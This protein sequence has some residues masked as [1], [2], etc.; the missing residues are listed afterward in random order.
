M[1]CQPLRRALNVLIGLEE[2][3]LKIKDMNF[4]KIYSEVRET[5]VGDV[6]KKY[7]LECGNQWEKVA[8]ELFK[9]HLSFTP[10]LQGLQK[11]LPQFNNDIAE[12]ALLVPGYITRPE[13]M[14]LQ[15]LYKTNEIEALKES[16]TDIVMDPFVRAWHQNDKFCFLDVFEDF[17]EYIH[18][19]L[20]C[21]YQENY[22]A[23]YVSL[24]PI[25]EGVLSRWYAFY[26]GNTQWNFE[27]AKK[28][29]SKSVNRQPLPFDPVFTE[30]YVNGLSVLISEH[31]FLDTNSKAK[32]F[33]FFN[34]H[35]ALHMLDGEGFATKYNVS[36][37]FLI[38]DLMSIVYTNE[39]K[40][41]DEKYLF[42]LYNTEYENRDLSKWLHIYND[43]KQFRYK[44][45]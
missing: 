24:L 38:L 9:I 11:K 27:K 36:R 25:I 45:I 29:I 1:R 42:R 5:S 8:K 16:L 20:I 4:E 15:Y 7:S 14:K 3:S 18:S 13:L 43:A 2:L 40:I 19:S 28:F 39:R 35:Q 30:I 26:H 6:R 34:R 33:D 41:I 23:A 10:P 21:Y 44:Y 22:K 31:L 17:H 12:L 32:S 37:L